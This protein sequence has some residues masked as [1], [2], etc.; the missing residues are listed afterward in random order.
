[1]GPLSGIRVLDFSRAIA[2]PYGTMILGD[3]GAEIIKIETPEGDFS[4]VT[5]GPSHKGENFY[6]LAFNR[7]KKDIVLDL[8][9]KSGR[10]ALYDLVKISD[11]VW[12]NFRA[13]SMERLSADY[14]TLRRINPG[15]IYCSIT[16]YGSS[17][18][19]KDRPAYDVAVLA[20]SGI[21]SVT[22]EP[23]GRPVRP[24][25]PIADEA[26]ALFAVIG[27]LAA[28][29]E[30]QRSGKGQKIDISLMDAC[31]SLLGYPL[32]YYSTTHVVPKPLGNSGH[33]ILVPYGVYKT[34]KGYIALGV[35]WPRITKVVG[36][37]W[38]A[39]DPR[40][41]D[42]PAR[43]EHRDE[44]N[45]IIEECL[46]KAEADDWLK[47]FQIEDIA[48]EKV[49]TLDEVSVDPQVL[50]QKMILTM[51]HSLGGEI[52]LAG[53]P[54][55]MEGIAE[56]EFIPPPTLNQHQ[57]EILAELLGYSEKKIQ[58]LREEESRN[59]VQRLQH[60]QRVL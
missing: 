51:E 13:G 28:L 33:L 41:I 5:A 27:V 23:D 21:L 2:G 48:A 30:R 32:S 24:G 40:F 8:L 25:V 17:G 39:D 34:K 55:K 49:A 31:I 29:A 1:M 52:Q 46:A 6:Y 44:L 15:I 57:H 11:I 38:L 56:E 22:G 53:N 35:C 59:T 37:D 12:N 19:S 42:L 9:T 14:D 16:G 50:H 36:A 58:R 47:I 3:L 26:G 54:V 7:N 43:Q 10:E 20:A 45:A 4:R 60:I 18:P